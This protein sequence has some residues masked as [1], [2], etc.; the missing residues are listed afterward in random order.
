MEALGD[1]PS[2]QRPPTNP[3]RKL[4]GGGLV[5]A[6]FDIDPLYEANV[7]ELVNAAVSAVRQ[8]DDGKN[9]T[10]LLDVTNTSTKMVATWVPS[11]GINKQEI[12]FVQGHIS[13]LLGLV[14]LVE[15]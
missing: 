1:I 5:D 4:V 10:G 3:K 12:Q 7:G 15:R 8:T 6:W 2:L 9:I 14:T 13:K 11:G